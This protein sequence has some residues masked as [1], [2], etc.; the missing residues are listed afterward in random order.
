MKHIKTQLR[1]K[2]SRPTSRREEPISPSSGAEEVNQE[3]ANQQ[4]TI[5]REVHQRSVKIIYPTTSRRV[6][7]T[8]STQEKRKDNLT[9]SRRV[10]GPQSTQEKRKDNITNSSCQDQ[11]SAVQVVE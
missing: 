5:K 11:V 4:A 6:A 2:G 3:G 7:G 9:T 8:R 10:A 1:T